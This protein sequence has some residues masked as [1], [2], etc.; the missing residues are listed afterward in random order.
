MIVKTL[1]APCGGTIT[2]RAETQ[3]E[4]DARLEQLR[5]DHERGG[6]GCHVCRPPPRQSGPHIA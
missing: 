3:L 1:R 5:K 6:P 4:I 2:V